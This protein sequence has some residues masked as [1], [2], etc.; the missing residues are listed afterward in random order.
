MAETK[1]P[2]SV[3][4]MKEL[5]VLAKTLGFQD[6]VAYFEKELAKAGE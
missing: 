3:P 1:P 2:W 4:E 6:D 5:L